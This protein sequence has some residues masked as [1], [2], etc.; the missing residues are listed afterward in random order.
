MRKPTEPRNSKV[1][2][3]NKHDTDF[4]HQTISMKDIIELA[5][6]L[7]VEYDIDMEDI[8]FGLDNEDC[9]D[10][11]DQPTI[12]AC[13]EA[14]R[15]TEDEMAGFMRVYKIQLETYEKY[16]SDNRSYLENVAIQKEKNSKRRKEL[17]N[18]IS[19]L[20]NELNCLKGK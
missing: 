18:S 5:D 4:D 8:S 7:S 15:Y 20:E 12:Y 19:K 10:V 14:D 6:A 2:R 13:G 1:T 3:Y 16:L 11:G 9:Y 17:R